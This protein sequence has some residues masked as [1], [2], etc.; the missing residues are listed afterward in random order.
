MKSEYCHHSHSCMPSD[1]YH[2]T[3]IESYYLSNKTDG[4]RIETKKKMFHF[5]KLAQILTKTKKKTDNYLDE[6]LQKLVRWLKEHLLLS[7]RTRVGFPR[8]TPSQSQ[9]LNLQLQDSQY[10]LASAESCT[11]ECITT[12]RHTCTHIILNKINLG[13]H[14]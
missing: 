3:L 8:P 5:N 1:M 12:Y 4:N 7:H 13:K 10:F 6:V 14:Q 9:P 2:M 11:Y